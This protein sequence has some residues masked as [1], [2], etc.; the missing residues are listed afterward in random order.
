MYVLFHNLRQ[1]LKRV[2][3]NNHLLKQKNMYRY[4]YEIYVVF[5]FATTLYGA[6]IHPFMIIAAI[7]NLW[8]GGLVIKS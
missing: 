8:T 3:N 6:S 2:S 7:R 1:K 4:I 5:Y